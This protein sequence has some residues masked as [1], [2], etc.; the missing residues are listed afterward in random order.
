MSDNKEVLDFLRLRFARIEERMDKSDGRI[1]EVINRLGRVERLVAD[2]HGQGAEHS[3]RMDRI[4]QLIE[5]I[6]RRLDLV[7]VP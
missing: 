6:E 3:V 5:R 7:Q 1:D 2:L 4:A